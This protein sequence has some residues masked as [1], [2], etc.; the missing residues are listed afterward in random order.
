MGVDAQIFGIGV[1]AG[2]ALACGVRQT[3][4]IEREARQGEKLVACENCGRIL[5]YT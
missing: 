4:A 5:V 3:M 2:W 1:L